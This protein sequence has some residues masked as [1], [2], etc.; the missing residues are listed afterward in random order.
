MVLQAALQDLDASDLVQR[1]AAVADLSCTAA[2]AAAVV[3]KRQQQ[4]QQRR[5]RWYMRFHRREGERRR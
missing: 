4:E 2:A 5:P 3:G 1:T